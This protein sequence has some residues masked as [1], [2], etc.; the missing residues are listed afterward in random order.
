MLKGTPQLRKHP[1]FTV[2]NLCHFKYTIAA[3]EFWPSLT[4]QLKKK[5][6]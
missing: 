4:S 5:W 2:D 6:M 3:T 1:V